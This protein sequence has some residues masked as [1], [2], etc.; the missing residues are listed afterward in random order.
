MLCVSTLMCQRGRDGW[1]KNETQ[2]IATHFPYGSSVAPKFLSK[3]ILGLETLLPELS[4][5]LH[6]VPVS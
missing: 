5:K 4:L 2:E 3:G 6:S 1:M